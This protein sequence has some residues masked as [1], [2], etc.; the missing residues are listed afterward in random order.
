[1]QRRT[2]HDADETV[3]IVYIH[4][5][6][7]QQRGDTQFRNGEFRNTAGNNFG[8]IHLIVELRDEVPFF[9]YL[10]IDVQGIFLSSVIQLDKRTSFVDLVAFFVQKIQVYD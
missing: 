8:Q 2:V 1:M 5:E 9:V 7:A 6:T 4:A 10:R 3:Q